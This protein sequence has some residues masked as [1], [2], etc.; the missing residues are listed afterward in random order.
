MLDN[1]VSNM[2]KSSHN[3][4][5]GNCGYKKVI[6]RTCRMCHVSLLAAQSRSLDTM[7]SSSFYVHAIIRPPTHTTALQTSQSMAHCQFPRGHD[8]TLGRDTENHSSFGRL[9]L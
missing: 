5:D 8:F 1:G 2:S 7:Q 4:K 6:E 9:W 3:V